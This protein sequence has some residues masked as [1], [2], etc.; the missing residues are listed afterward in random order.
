MVYVGVDIAKTDHVACAV[1]ET[2]NK[3]TRPLP[4]RNT[5]E[6][7]ERLLAWIEGVAEDSAEVFVAMEATGHYW[8]AYFA[9]LSTQ[10][11]KAC[12]VNPL[13]VKAMRGL[14]GAQRVKNDRIDSWLIAE[15]LHLGDISEMR[16][17]TDEIQSLTTLT[18]YHQGLKQ[19]LATAKTQRLCVL[20][21][22]FPEYAS[23]FS[24]V[25]GHN[26][27]A[28]LKKCPIPQE[29]C[30]VHAS[31][32]VACITTASR[33]RLGDALAA[34]LKAAAKSS[35]G[36]KLGEEAASFQIK[37]MVAQ[38]EFLNSTIAKVE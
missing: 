20:D 16:L 38:T 13:Q 8:M 35:I 32:L 23:H 22:Y 7:F 19:E 24:D 3:L 33:G 12:V 21:S 25:L 31:T 30:R 1:D 37:S 34:K 26:S 5:E 9:Y 28:V 6:G 18:R 4:F 15:T 10:G 36:I 27:L 11:I 14:K 17:A 29:L 2:G